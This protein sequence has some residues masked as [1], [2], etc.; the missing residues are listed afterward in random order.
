MSSMDWVMVVGWMAAIVI[1]LYVLGMI[2]TE[3]RK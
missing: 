3:L 2:V 1:G